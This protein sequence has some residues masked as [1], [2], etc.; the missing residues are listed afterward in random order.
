MTDKSF[1]CWEMMHLSIKIFT[2]GGEKKNK[3]G[4][5]IDYNEFINNSCNVHSADILKRKKESLY[6]RFYLNSNRRRDKQYNLF[7]G[8]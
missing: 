6:C 4:Y 1:V 8:I 5:R 2:F 7:M 3:F